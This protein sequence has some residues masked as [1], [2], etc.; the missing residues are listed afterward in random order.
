[1]R[2]VET[3]VAALTVAGPLGQF[4]PAATLDGDT[5]FASTV[6]RTGTVAVSK[7][8]GVIHL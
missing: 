8:I 3:T 2:K 1:M 4:A 7:R 6:R 5:R